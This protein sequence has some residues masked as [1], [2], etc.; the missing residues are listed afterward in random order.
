MG[1]FGVW[2]LLLIFGIVLLIFGAGKLPKIARDLGGGIKEFKKS[3]S[4]ESPP[5]DE[6]KNE[7]KT[8]NTEGSGTSDKS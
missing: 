5:P 4:N 2:E 1:G 7:S 8:S 6:S 3:I